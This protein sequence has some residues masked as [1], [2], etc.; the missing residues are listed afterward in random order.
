MPADARA[1]PR[2][3]A[4]RGP[5]G[6]PRRATRRCSAELGIE[7]GR[8]CASWSARSSRRIR[9]S[10]PLGGSPRLVH[11]RAERPRRR[12]KDA[13]RSSRYSRPASTM[14]S[15]AAAVSSSSSA[16]PAR[17]RRDSPTS[18]RAARSSAEP[19]LLGTRLGRR[20]RTRVL[21]VDAGAARRVAARPEPDEPEAR[22]SFFEAVTEMLR[23]EGRGAA[24]PAR[25]RRSPGGGR[26]LDRCCWSSSQRSC[27]R[28]RRSSWRSDVPR[29]RG[30]TSSSATQRGSCGSSRGRPLRASRGRPSPARRGRSWRRAPRAAPPQLR[31]DPR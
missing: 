3:P 26:K 20:R 31:A 22:F 24:A 27:P 13:T 8:R 18:W 29:R 17:A 16:T 25:A 1:L 4:G 28:C 30:S 23:G 14:R 7:P 12:S 6:V 10:M 2:W 19:D 5:R 21:A 11:G 9:G 15:R